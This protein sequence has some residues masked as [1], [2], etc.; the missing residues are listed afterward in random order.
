M[1]LLE[2]TLIR[3]GNEEYARDNGSVGLTTMRDQHATVNGAAVRF[4]FRGK[5]GIEHAIDLQR[6]AA[7]AHRQGVPRPA[8]LRAVQYVDE[9]GTRQMI[10]SADVNDVPARDQRRGFHRQGL[11]HLGRHGARG[12][13]ARRRRR[14]SSRTTEAKRNIVQAI[15]SVAKRLGNTKAVCRKCY[16]HPGDPRRLHGR[17]DVTIAERLTKRAPWIAVVD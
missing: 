14:R 7:G 6:R 17:R 16:I 1:Q 12:E 2:K 5:S 13:G 3:V 15:E 9:D 8:G 4:E 11:P 10:D